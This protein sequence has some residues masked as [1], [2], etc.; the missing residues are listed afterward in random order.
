M[1]FIRNQYAVPTPSFGGCLNIVMTMLV[2]FA[3][4]ILCC[5]VPSS[6]SK[7]IIQPVF[8]CGKCDNLITNPSNHKCT[9]KK[10]V[11]I[12]QTKAN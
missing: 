10:G 4:L 12:I 1:L 8:H 5:G 9:E 11:I 7:R 2:A 6:C 3:M